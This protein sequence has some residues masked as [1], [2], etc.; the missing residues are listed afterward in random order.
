[1]PL[2]PF[3]RKVETMGPFKGT[4]AQRRRWL[5][6]VCLALISICSFPF[7]FVNQPDYNHIAN[8]VGSAVFGGM[9]LLLYWG[10]SYRL[11]VHSLLLAGIVY[12]LYLAVNTGGINS[13]A[14]VW[15]TVIV[16]PALML[17]GRGAAL[18]WLVIAVLIN[19]A[20]TYFTQ[21][22]F[23]SD[24]VRQENE[25]VFWNM[26]SKFCVIGLLMVATHLSDRMHRQQVQELVQS[27][28]EL[29]ETHR[30]LVKAQAYKDEFIASVGHELRTPMNAI[31]GLNG[32]LRSE[33][34]QN[35][36]ESEI[37]EHIRRSTERLLKVVNDILDFSQLQAGRLVLREEKFSLIETIKRAAEEFPLLA[38]QKGLAFKVDVDSVRR[39]WV[40]GD[41]Q[42]LQQIIKNLLD[43]AFKFTAHGSVQLRVQ[44]AGTDI[45]F[46]VIDTGIGIAEERRQQ[47][48]HRFEHA[49]IQTNRQY[50][51]TGLGLSICERLVS[52]QS[53]VIGV[54]SSVGQ[55]SRFWF[56][57]P[58]ETVKPR[59]EEK[60]I[61]WSEEIA[62]RPLNILI[63]DDN[64]VNLMVAQLAFKRSLPLASVTL[65]SSGQEALEY[66]RKQAFDLALIDM[67]MPGMDG[68]EVTRIIRG[69]FP[70]PLCHMPILALTANTNPVDE[71]QCLKAGMDDIVHKPIDEKQLIDRLSFCLANSDVEAA[72]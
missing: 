25:V 49:D 17:L 61:L 70:K 7:Y 57:L 11:M 52:L 19:A 22:G 40:R 33:L 37:V 60:A 18:I 38:E 30:A 28:D 43:N 5:L 62:H 36:Q 23:V 26:L 4:M 39:T 72:P 71:E 21:I 44:K 58:L 47:I 46:E 68:L 6:M 27:N 66:L 45:L 3:K 29:E 56:L 10:A 24:Y 8:L 13:P 35:Q 69:S 65:A 53:G 20:L 12:V 55:G 50:G 67:V 1:M 34:A 9:F 16:L 59:D 32:V 14:M 63:V 31:L 42:R 48:F 64:V 51:G 2:R 41:A 15:M 54:S